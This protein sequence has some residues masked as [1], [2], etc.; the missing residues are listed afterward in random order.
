M[1]KVEPTGKQK[2]AFKELVENG[3][4]KGDAMVKAG[5]SKNTAKA[6]T[7]MTNSKGWKELTEEYLPDKLLAKKHKELLEV[8]IKK[9]QWIKGEL[10]YE[11]EELDTNAVKSGLDMAYK[12]KGH[13]AP[14]KKTIEISKINELSPEELEEKRRQIMLGEITDDEIDEILR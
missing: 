11:T 9:R 5:Y 12:L 2:R 3:R 7:K 4:T 1:G 14:E 6:P 8:P 13:Y 10:Q